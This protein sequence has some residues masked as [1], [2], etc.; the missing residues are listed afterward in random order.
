M[1]K[2]LKAHN[3]K[4]D[5]FDGSRILNVLKGIDLEI[6]RGQSIAIVGTS[7]SGKSTLMHIL[8]ALDRPTTGDVELSGIAYSTRSDDELAKIRSAKVGFV[9][10]FHHLLSEFSALENAMIPALIK[11]DN[12]NDARAKAELLLRE[13]GLGDRLTHRPAK[14]SGGEQQRVALVRALI[15]EPDIIFAD[16]PTGNLD[17]KTSEE[18][19]ELLWKYTVKKDKSLVIVTHDQG[20]AMKAERKLHL[21]DGIFIS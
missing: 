18:I 19:V 7:G 8:G 3:I 9:F 11:G 4:K 20:I 16:E 5:Y 13:V 14:L 10:Q 2:L 1:S 12:K 17:S 21:K 6:E 15:N